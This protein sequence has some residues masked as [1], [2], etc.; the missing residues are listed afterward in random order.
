MSSLLV[1]QTQ[2]NCPPGLVAE[3]A[4]RRGMTLDVLRVDRWE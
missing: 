3:W 1:L 4:V 2:D